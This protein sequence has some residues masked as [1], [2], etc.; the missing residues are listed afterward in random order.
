MRALTQIIGDRVTQ[1]GIE[2]LL[3]ILPGHLRRIRLVG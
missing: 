1:L 3:Q 2:V